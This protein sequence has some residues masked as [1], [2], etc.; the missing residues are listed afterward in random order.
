MAE[1][2]L[3]TRFK[4]FLTLKY[5]GK[6]RTMTT[7]LNI[8]HTQLY[9]KLKSGNLTLEQ[10]MIDKIA[11]RWPDVDTNY[12][13]TGDGKLLLHDSTVHEPFVPYTS[14]KLHQEV[15][16]SKDEVIHMQKVVIMRTEQLVNCK[17][18]VIKRDQEIKSVLYEYNTLLKN[19]AHAR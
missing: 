8:P 4:E 5:R 13:Q 9:L 12:I 3:T 19:T 11:H 10:Y 16:K 7:E 15:I 2:L 14:K 1:T 18:E 17:D 6:L